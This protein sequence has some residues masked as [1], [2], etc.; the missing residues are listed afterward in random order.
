MPDSGTHE[1]HT[2]AVLLLALSP[3]LSL[4]LISSITGDS[5]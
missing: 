5:Q 3:F 1:I 2:N 4:S